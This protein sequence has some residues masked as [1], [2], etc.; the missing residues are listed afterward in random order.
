VENEPQRCWVNSQFVVAEGNLKSLR[1]M[2]PDGY[3]IPVSPYYGPTTVLSAE[4]DGD[5]VI[6]SWIEIIVSSGKY[7][8]EAMFPLAPGI[9]FEPIT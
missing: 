7:E 5:K 1:S 9:G 3:K 4:R 8:N 6:V 2:Y